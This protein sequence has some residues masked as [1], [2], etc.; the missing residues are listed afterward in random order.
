MKVALSML[1]PDIQRILMTSLNTAD[2]LRNKAASDKISIAPS[3]IRVIDMQSAYNYIDQMTPVP[4][5]KECS[6]VPVVKHFRYG[7]THVTLTLETS[8]KHGVE[9]K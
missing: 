5:F 6:V 3:D 2:A 1:K 4:D 9:Y 7:V 8:V